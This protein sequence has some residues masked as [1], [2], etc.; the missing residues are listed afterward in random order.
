MTLRGGVRACLMVVVPAIVVSVSAG[1]GLLPDDGDD[2]EAISMS[3]AE[4]S[5]TVIDNLNAV[6]PPADDVVRYDTP[7]GDV[8][9]VGCVDSFPSALPTGPPWRYVAR[10]DHDNPDAAR[11]DQWRASAQGL[12]S[13]GFVVRPQPDTRD[14]RNVTV[15]DSRKFTVGVLIYNYPVSQLLRLEI[16]SSSPCV[17]DPSG[18]DR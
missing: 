17:R 14:P 4:A 7:T 13:K 9:R 5:R 6:D 16:S 8:T 15:S 18:G 3:P 1:C 11:I 2:V 10:R 12:V